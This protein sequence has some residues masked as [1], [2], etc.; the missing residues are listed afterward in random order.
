M[1]GHCSF[2]IIGCANSTVSKRSTLRERSSREDVERSFSSEGRGYAWIQPEPVVERERAARTADSV[3]LIVLGHLI[4]DDDGAVGA[5]RC[6]RTQEI[7]SRRPNLS[8]QTSFLAVCITH[9][10]NFPVYKT[11]A[12]STSYQ[13]DLSTAHSVG[14]LLIYLGRRHHWRQR[15]ETFRIRQRA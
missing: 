1:S 14:V 8:D 3:F 7:K 11:W 12:F 4:L 15:P 9:L 10:F 2:I 13:Y 6:L 5:E